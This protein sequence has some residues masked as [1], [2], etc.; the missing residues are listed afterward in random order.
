MAKTY[1]RFLLEAKMSRNEALKIFGLLGKDYNEE[2]LKKLYRKLSIE[3]HP[4]MGGDID[5][6][7]DINV[8]YEVLGGSSGVGDY[9][10]DDFLK[11]YA[12]RQEKEKFYGDIAAKSFEKSFD[13]EAF[14]G[15]FNE[16]FGKTFKMNVKGPTKAGNSVGYV[17]T[18]KAEGSG[19]FGNTNIEMYVYVSYLSLYGQATLSSGEED[20]DLSAW[21]Q[22]Y[23]EG[24]KVKL[25]PRNWRYGS[26]HSVLKNPEILFPKSKILIRKEKEKARKIS[27][28]D[29]IEI[30]E[31]EL[32]AQVVD[33]NRETS[34]V[35]PLGGDYNITI[36]RSV[37]MGMAAW[38]LST[39]SLKQGSGRQSKHIGGGISSPRAYM[40]ESQQSIDF[41][42][43]K[44]KSIQ[45]LSNHTDENILSAI[46]DMI[47]EFKR[48]S[49]KF[50]K[51]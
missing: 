45:A 16:V 20:L 44:I 1:K 7:K 32:G 43:S 41:F 5:K 21:S 29:I 48:R 11:N 15:Y 30:L 51:K 23:H 4:D 27:K 36:S 38:A 47:E 31:S 9:E 42:V 8:A 10:R 33:R 2:D 50:I 22:I 40:Y 46:T 28:R 26:D 49:E 12:Q 24:R 3:N 14:V 13:G 6:M 19:T 39:Y 37:L 34:A 35:V 17:I 25:E 18:F